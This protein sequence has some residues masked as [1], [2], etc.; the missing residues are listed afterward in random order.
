MIPKVLP[1][2]TDL[3]VL[4][5]RPAAQCALLCEEIVRQ[6][7]NAIAFP[8]V[9]IEPL[10]V[11]TTVASIDYDLIVFVSVNAVEHGARSVT[12]SA[13]AV[14]AETSC[15]NRRRESDMR[16]SGRGVRGI[17]ALYMRIATAM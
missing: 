4:V 17:V 16:S 9:Q 3:T 13:L 2:L 15:R 8:A 10:A 14:Q 11:Q 12:K 1:P 6:G 7:G 5:T